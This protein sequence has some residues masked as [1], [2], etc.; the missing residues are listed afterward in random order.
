MNEKTL[1][2]QLGGEAGIR[3]LAVIFYRVM[4][5]LPEAKP[6]R[7]M[8]PKDLTSSTE[9]LALFLIGWLGGPP[10]YEQKYG[11][12]R[13]RAR[14]LPFKIGKE[15]RDQWILCMVQAFDEKKISEPIR[16][17]ILYSLLNLANH[18]QNYLP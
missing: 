15:E 3:E 13:L 7:L 8:H 6:I 10:L 17:E 11:H 4:D 18:M 5:E 12:P 2:E 9:K 14:H 1:F 16:S